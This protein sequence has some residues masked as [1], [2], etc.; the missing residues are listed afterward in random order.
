MIRVIRSLS[1]HRSPRSSGLRRSFGRTVDRLPLIGCAALVI[2]AAGG[3]VA[4]ARVAASAIG[5]L[6][7][8]AAS[9]A[10]VAPEKLVASDAAVETARRSPQP[11]ADSDSAA[12]ST[13]RDSA[14][15]ARPPR[16]ASD[17]ARSRRASVGGAPRAAGESDPDPASASAVAGAAPQHAGP[18]SAEQ[19]DGL[20]EVAEAIA[21]EWAEWL[22]NHRE[23]DPEALRRAIGT[24][25]RRL[26]ALAVLREQ[27]PDLYALK[28]DE[29]RIQRE[30]G[31]VGRRYRIAAA[32]GD[33]AAASRLLEEL[34]QKV[35]QQVDKEL[36]ARAAELVALDLQLKALQKQLEEE[37]RQLTQD[38]GNRAARIDDLVRSIATL[39]GAPTTPPPPGVPEAGVAAGSTAPPTDAPGSPPTN[40]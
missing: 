33:E 32:A 31:D 15:Q 21:P 12:P 2:F 29:L 22:R 7:D 37:H 4:Q 23:S 9:G 8:S 28:I 24:H 3:A 39:R 5:A 16:P 19:V 10:S 40:R 18:L 30:V 26:V 38:T 34:R 11:A 27:S 17:A 1:L 13:S 6:E 20:I 14:R 35:T 25:G 36:R